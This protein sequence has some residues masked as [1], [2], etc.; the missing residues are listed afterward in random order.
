MMRYVKTF[1]LLVVP[2]ALPG[3]TGSFQ[4]MTSWMGVSE[5]ELMRQ[6][7]QPHRSSVTPFG[8]VYS[9]YRNA[10]DQLGCTDDFTIKGGL[11]RGFASNCGI[12]GGFG[13]PTYRQ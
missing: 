3:C 4:K 1:I 13:V 12:W 2:L 11:I 7:G 9:W 8:Q 6:L 5:A 10:D